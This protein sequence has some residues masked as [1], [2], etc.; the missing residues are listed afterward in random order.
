M[1]VFRVLPWNTKCDSDPLAEASQSGDENCAVTTNAFSATLVAT[2][3]VSNYFYARPLGI[4]WL[5]FQHLSSSCVRI[6]HIENRMAIAHW[7]LSLSHT[8]RIQVRQRRR[9]CFKMVWTLFSKWVC[10]P[11][12]LKKILSIWSDVHFAFVRCEQSLTLA[13]WL[14]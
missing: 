5:V 9:F 8:C 6:L 3:F 7:C 10:F 12:N 11:L 2:P 14:Y 4:S 13:L 1:V